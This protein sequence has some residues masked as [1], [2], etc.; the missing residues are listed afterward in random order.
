[1]PDIKH[2]FRKGRMNKDLDERLVPN[3]E[4]RDAQNIEIITSEG[5]GVGSVQNVLGNT[6][7][8]G[9][10]Y[11]ENSKALTLWGSNS[12]SIKDL[13]D[14]Q[15]I[16]FVVDE[17][18]NK[19]YWFISSSE[20]ITALVNESV[21]A[22]VNDN[23]VNQSST[24]NIDTISSPVSIGDI[25]T[26][27]GIVGEVKV[28]AIS[29]VT[30]GLQVIFIDSLQ[31]INDN[32]VLTFIKP[33]TEVIIDSSSGTIKT[34]MTVTGG[35]I[36]GKTFVT[37]VSGNT[38][39]V[40]N[41]VYL[42]NN[43]LLIFKSTVSCI[44]EYNTVT[45]VVCPVLVD[46]NNILN[47]SPNYLITGANVLNGLLL[48]TD[49]Q[50]EPKK[51]IISDCKAGSST[52]NYHT[53]IN[54][55]D[56][57]ERD[58]TVIR[59]HPLNAPTLAMDVSE[60]TLSKRGLESGSDVFV[61][62]DFYNGT[63][64]ALTSGTDITLNFNPLGNFI[65]DDILKLK[66]EDVS[67]SI[68][69][70][71]EI[72]VK[73]KTL[74]N[75]TVIS[76]GNIDASTYSAVCVIQS[77]PENLKDLKSVTW[78][79]T[80]QEKK[81]IFEE[82]FVRFAYRWKYKDNQYSAFSPF[83]KIAF[84]PGE[85]NYDNLDA[86]NSAMS[87]NLRTLTISGFDSKPHDVSEVEIL[88][89]ESNINAVYVV[90]KL[91][92]GES[93]YNV[94]N[95]NIRFVIESNQILRPYDN[96]P[97]TAK[98]QEVTASRVIYGN[99][100]Q[101]Y[102]TLNSN[103][104]R[105]EATV[106]QKPTD[107]TTTSKASPR[108]TGEKNVFTLKNP[109]S[110]IEVGMKVTSDDGTFQSEDN[111]FVLS[112]DNQ[113]L[114]IGKQ[115]TSSTNTYTEEKQ[116]EVTGEIIFTFTKRKTYV[117]TV[118]SLRNYQL[119]AT[120][121]DVFGRESP[122][123]SSINSSVYLDKTFSN[124]KNTLTGKLKNTAPDWAT[125]FK[126]FVKET[127]SEYYNI[128]LDRF[129]FAQDGNIWLSFPS[130]ERNKISEDTFLLLKKK[131]DKS[132]VVIEDARY[133][134]LDI[135]N[136][137]P[138]FIS[139][140][141]IAAGKAS[142]KIKGNAPTVGSV[143]FKFS[144]PSPQE[145]P[146]FASAFKSK[147]QIEIT[148]NVDGVFSDQKN[149]KRY[150]IKSGGSSNENVYEVILE[151]PI[152]PQDSG[153][154]K[155][156]TSTTKQL[157][158]EVNVDNSVTVALTAENTLIEIGMFV[159]GAGI[160]SDDVTVTAISTATITLSSAQ[161]IS[162]N[163]EL[164]FEKITNHVAFDSEVNI[165][166][167]SKEIKDKAEFFGRFFVKVKRDFIIDNNIINSFN[168][169]KST[170]EQSEKQEFLEE[171]A[172]DYTH[173]S[174]KNNEATYTQDA[175]WDDHSDVATSLGVKKIPNNE[176]D[177]AGKG[178]SETHPSNGKNKFSFY[179]SAIGTEDSSEHNKEENINSFITKLTKRGS[180]IQ[181][182]NGF[183][184]KGDI[185]QVTGS[186]FI[187]EF[188]TF[189]TAIQK[190]PY[191]KRRLYTI[192]I[193]N[194]TTKAKTY[195]DIFDY[196]IGTSDTAGNGRIN[197]ISIMEENVALEDA[198]I[199]SDNPAIFETEPK[200]L[201]G[202]DIYYE[203]SNSLP[204]IKPGMKVTGDGI[205]T[206]ISATT[207]SQTSNATVVLTEDLSNSIIQGMFMTGIG[208]P[209]N[210]TVRSVSGTTVTLSKSSTYLSGVALTFST[211]NFVDSVEDGDQFNLLNNVATDISSVDKDNN[212]IGT[213]LTFTD[214]N[215]LY[216]FTAKTTIFNPNNTENSSGQK[217]IKL[218]TN[219]VHGQAIDLNFFNA[220]TFG[221]GVE[222]NRIKDDF[223]APFI[224]RGVVV[225]TTLDAEYK[226]EQKESGLIFSGIFNSTSGVNELN[227]FIQ[228]LP[229]TK[230]INP[231]YGSI[232]KLHVRETDL[233]AFCE[234]KVLKILTNKDALFNADG[235]TNL[236]A[237]NNVLGQTIGYV[238]E[239]GISKNPESFAS[240]AFR[241]YFADK[242]RGAVLR[243]SRDGLT[244]ISEKGM[245]D[246]FGDN[247]AA[248]STILGTYN[249]DKGSYNITLNNK[250]VS[251]D[252]R[253]DG[254]T[255]FKS[256]LPESGLSINN[257]YYTFKN[258]DLY[259]HDNLVRNTFYETKSE[260]AS[261]V[262]NSTS[263]TLSKVNSNIEVGMLISGLGISGEVTVSAISG[264]SLTL[265]SAQTIDQYVNLS[266]VKSYESSVNVLFNDI[267]TSVKSFKTLNYEGSDSRKYTYGG[268]IG[269]TT[270][271]DGTTLEVL[272]KS[273]YTGTQISGLTETATKGWYAD[274]I[275]TDQQTGSV[276]FFK[277]K[278]NF[279]FNKI[280]GDTTTSS[281]ID[282][283]ELSVQGL[284][285][286]ASVSV[287]GDNNFI[288]TVQPNTTGSN[289][290]KSDNVTFSVLTSDSSGTVGSG[291][292]AVFT[293]TPDTG[294]VISASQVSA[295]EIPTGITSS[296]SISDIGTAGTAGNTVT[297]TFNMLSSHGINAASTL[298]P[299]I[300]VTELSL[301]QYNIVGTYNTDESNT[302]GSS[303]YNFGYSASGDYFVNAT[304]NGE[305]NGSTLV[306]LASAN[307]LI[308]SGMTVVGSGI[309]IRTTVS[310]ISG[311]TLTL[312]KVAT[313]PDDTLLKFG[314]EIISKTF[315]ANDGF[316]FPS[317]L[318]LNVLKEDENSIS[319]YSTSS[320][321]VVVEATKTNT[322][323]VS[324]T[325]FVLDSVTGI[326]AT[327]IVTGEG[328]T[329]P[330]KVISINSETKTVTVDNSVLIQSGKILNFTP[331]V[332]VFKVHYVFSTNNPIE[333][334]LLITA[335]AGK[336]FLDKPDEIT[337]LQMSKQT[338]PTSGEVR[339][340]QVVG[341]QEAKFILREF[342]TGVTN[343]AVNNSKSITLTE[344][345][346]AISSGM[347]VT[348]GGS[349]VGK[350]DTFSGAVIT[351]DRN[352]TL[353]SGDTL[354]FRLEHN[355]SEFT[356]DITSTD[357]P[358][359]LTMPSNGVRTFVRSYGASVNT[360]IFN[361]EVLSVS[362]TNLSSTFKGSNP[363]TVSQFADVTF[364]VKATENFLDTEA[365]LGNTNE[366]SITKNA[367]KNDQSEDIDFSFAITAA[368]GKKLREI[369]KPSPEDFKYATITKTVKSISDAVNV[370][371][372]CT[373]V[374][375]F[376][377]VATQSSLVVGT[378]ITGMVVK[379][380]QKRNSSN[381]SLPDGVYLKSLLP[382]ANLNKVTIAH[383]TKDF[384][385][386]A[387]AIHV[388]DTISFSSPYDYELSFIKLN[389]LMKD[390]SGNEVVDTTA[391]S[392][393]V[394]NSTSV[395]LEKA[396]NTIT[397]GMVVSSPSVPEDV[398]VTGISTNATSGVMTL[399]ISS[400]KTINA[401]EELTFFE[402]DGN[403]YTVSGTAQINKFG[404][405]SITSE[406]LFDKFVKSLAL[407]NNDVANTYAETEVK[408]TINGNSKGNGGV[409][410]ATVHPNAKIHLPG[411]AKYTLYVGTG[412]DEN[413]DG[414]P[415]T[416]GSSPVLTPN[417]TNLSFTLRLIF[418]KIE[419]Y[420]KFYKV[421]IQAKPNDV[422]NDFSVGIDSNTAGLYQNSD[423]REFLYTDGVPTDNVFEWD[424]SCNTSRDL[425]I[426][427]IRLKLDFEV[428]IT[429][430][431]GRVH[432]T[433]GPGAED[434]GTTDITDNTDGGNGITSGGNGVR[435]DLQDP[436]FQDRE[437]E[438]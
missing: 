408:F 155:E 187:S 223:N 261:A 276:K 7:K 72:F 332:V 269:G 267:P 337:E 280:L 250:T 132:E 47:F 387:S 256:F 172:N 359:T 10:V 102:D 423:V 402:D 363:T 395:I 425:T 203:S 171:L 422:F 153:V 35:G 77:I 180:L 125:H 308:S 62:F 56:F 331:T 319:E 327:M 309:P 333:D 204:I 46:K 199:S 436:E 265:S 354:T 40:S 159:K 9:K 375:E 259:S 150:T 11:D 73:I 388:G 87:N 182:S 57:I 169:I 334:R 85:F 71:Y 164:T 161:T 183:G 89:K 323:T 193:I 78:K 119:G 210:V 220:F 254:W 415:D 205:N 118:K 20:T 208:V 247:L 318:S 338:I 305:V 357:K 344:A 128:A 260:I 209:N 120:Y 351:M 217:V 381:P 431:P 91:R 317:D 63:E 94:L 364:K 430:E 291:K 386:L 22:T 178:I 245:S 370:G 241:I 80:L 105:I 212:P 284:G 310:S 100:K 146:D 104:P 255:S 229:I 437:P 311:T 61:D 82:R 225:S 336:A 51:V 294:Y 196:A 201:E 157:V 67:G 53:Q 307:S 111:M 358:T 249:E 124:T 355:G 60:R 374:V 275:T 176:K 236:T 65:K 350:V 376:I 341:R 326:V 234:D 127:S 18:N 257:I 13:T 304:V 262:S 115:K 27:A 173:S 24:I 315:T 92:N 117:E 244:S 121:S 50:T 152:L 174:D 149:S 296:V 160:T 213:I 37:G 405:A 162:A 1:M 110:K 230:D 251:F 177:R 184:T 79:A 108:S 325:T 271:G 285:I 216:S 273:G 34:G 301:I 410:L 81:P 226:E 339:E 123:F 286:P 70:I 347:T 421:K 158:S 15:C 281:N 396:N 302:T 97:K 30:N 45:G 25:V 112:I 4:Y 188:R 382:I 16:G 54:K 365:T 306:T 297:V 131:H 215:N 192:E 36:V 122:V 116:K 32:V 248:S 356:S 398:T 360:R 41:G 185:Y 44:A 114:E 298:S 142:C 320:D 19:I 175:A 404:T 90:D 12:S 372:G 145:N 138:R 264:S 139:T 17:Q 377:S 113:R 190:K 189:D 148:T 412:T 427:D 378:A 322:S 329:T 68:S 144:G 312:S 316:A 253:V 366:L 140:E 278:E 130:A 252:E 233:I 59:M 224:D 368:S 330:T 218:E 399:T 392:K 228:A 397:T 194:Y 195:T 29:D 86:Y 5:S 400:A 393:A 238:G 293:I 95:E 237:S 270:I 168:G 268:T 384:N 343:A 401:G 240:H 349:G 373:A 299:R 242:A 438:L 246:F 283:K 417:D 274:S 289:F 428:T 197:Q 181:F 58:I 206:V 321:H 353:V 38:I 380:D 99:Y 371:S 411:F 324:S 222:S 348:S 156:V 151:D 33:R 314:K 14:P 361:Y 83:S 42:T 200:S 235:N 433:F 39:S 6:L 391:I 414:I 84:L 272:K 416:N 163:T 207:A 379:T 166:I 345:N 31:T 409:A 96:V 328:I 202:L 101:G 407:S 136:E 109:N 383:D 3:G 424:F 420:K 403:N 389:G 143:F 21:T 26:G 69:V 135:S 277:D 266:F 103:I 313:I 179:W 106:E 219:Q 394:S 367:G 263:V 76:S 435:V 75:S 23:T 340:I 107:V 98:A 231:I 432:S 369:K 48:F 134:V 8:D 198:T 258:G 295:S 303:R 191:G 227:Q 390:G 429:E 418:S 167:F 74:T 290:T 352:V 335:K 52:F 413:N 282:T 64:K 88:L 170:F 426:N 419:S 186:T 287:T 406:F 288:L 2:H 28:T 133:K 141:T 211:V 243:L 214:E 129:Y 221:N 126:L 300:T 66:H 434:P 93:F 342:T 147:N 279:K 385:E 49:N 43:T 362:P 292:T 55:T 232:Q 239:Y 154:F 346:Y 165:T 137:A